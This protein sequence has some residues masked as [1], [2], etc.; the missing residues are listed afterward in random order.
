M[1]T[2]VL[3]DLSSNPEPTVDVPTVHE[4]NTMWLDGVCM[5]TDGCENIEPDGFCCHGHPSW[6]LHL[7]YL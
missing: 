3:D 6:L 5:A 7:G 1:T 2:L 4:I